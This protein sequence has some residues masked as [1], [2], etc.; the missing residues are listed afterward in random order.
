MMSSIGSGMSLLSPRSLSS[1]NTGAVAS[2][3]DGLQATRLA[4]RGRGRA[5]R[6]ADTIRD[7]LVRAVHERRDRRAGAGKER[8]EGARLAGGR[9][10]ARQLGIDRR[11]VGLVEAVLGQEAE[12][13]GAARREPGHA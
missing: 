7:G 8:A 2:E 4:E 1:D 5:E 6:R 10:Q 12:H 3:L 13:I 9:D 11:A